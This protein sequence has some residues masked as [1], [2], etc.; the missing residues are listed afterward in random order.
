MFNIIGWLIAG[1]VVGLLARLLVPGRQPLGLLA[2]TGLGVIGALAGG[3]AAK[4]L[5]G[6]PAD[7]T[8]AEAWPGYLTAILG[9]A[10]LLWIGGKVK[11]T[12]AAT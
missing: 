9:A 3:Y 8:T 4:A 6:G 5:T 12:N 10:I 11:G 1:L 7:P 2:T